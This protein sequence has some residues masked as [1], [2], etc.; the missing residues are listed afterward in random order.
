MALTTAALPERQRQQTTPW[1]RPM[2]VQAIQEPFDS[3]DYT[4]VIATAFLAHYAACIRRTIT[5][6][7][8]QKR[9]VQKSP[10]SYIR[11]SLPRKPYHR[12]QEKAEAASG[13]PVDSCS[14][15]IRHTP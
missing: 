8:I 2:L 13:N 14:V 7:Y 4:Y 12:M 10:R 11:Q 15:A 1:N 6:L 9:S 3:K 5:V